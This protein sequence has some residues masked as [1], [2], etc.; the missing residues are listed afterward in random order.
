MFRAADGDQ[1]P[2]VPYDMVAAMTCHFAADKK[3][4]EGGFGDVYQGAIGDPV[5]RRYVP[6]AVKVLRDVQLAGA[7]LELFHR[8][9][10]ACVHREVAL[11]SRFKHQHIIRL[12]GYSLP[13]QGGGA[14]RLCLIYELAAERGLDAYLQDDAKRARLPW[15]V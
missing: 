8:D 11:L 6:V 7:D 14:L 2:N 4:G 5:T 12:L 13:D 1:V 9:A 3:I 10:R 15:Q